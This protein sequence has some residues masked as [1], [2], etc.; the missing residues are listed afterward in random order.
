M[1]HKLSDE[2]DIIFISALVAKIVTSSWDMMT[3]TK[4]IKA[5]RIVDGCIQ[6][7]RR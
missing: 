7:Q 5:S 4:G 6:C 1:K 2:I 3:T